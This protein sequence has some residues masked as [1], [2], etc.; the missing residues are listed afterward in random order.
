MIFVVESDLCA[1]STLFASRIEAEVEVA[2]ID[3]EDRQQYLLDN[4]YPGVNPRIRL[5]DPKEDSF[6]KN[7]PD[8]YGVAPGIGQHRCKRIMRKVDAYWA[9]REEWW[10]DPRSLV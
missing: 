10:N 4:N 2:R 6:C 5:W 1:P 3:A 7:H 9:A 8:H